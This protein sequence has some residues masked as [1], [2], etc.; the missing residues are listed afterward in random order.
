MSTHLVKET[1]KTKPR[2]SVDRAPRNTLV[3]L[4]RNDR[5]AS[6]EESLYEAK[7]FHCFNSHYIHYR[8]AFQTSV[9]SRVFCRGLLV[10]CWSRFGYVV[11]LTT[12]GPL[13]GKGPY[14][15]A[16]MIGA[17]KLWLLAS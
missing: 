13:H 4:S 8:Q 9:W 1:K 12:R 7:K 3:I 10:S 2:T 17:S 15:Y 5:K 14:L 16:L 11:H 6:S